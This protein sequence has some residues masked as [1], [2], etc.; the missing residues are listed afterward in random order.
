VKRSKSL[1]NYL[2]AVSKT[3]QTLVLVSVEGNDELPAEKPM[4]AE[5]FRNY[6]KRNKTNTEA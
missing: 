4:L 2:S 1:L 6:F 3:S 5:A